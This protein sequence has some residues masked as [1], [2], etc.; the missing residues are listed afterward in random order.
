MR[1]DTFS[2]LGN[3]TP[4]WI[5]GLNN[6]FSFKGFT[7][8][9]LI[10]FVQGNQIT[11]DTRYQMM[12]NGTGKFTEQYRE[13]SAPLPGVVA[14]TT[15]T[16]TKYEKNTQLVDGQTAWAMRAW[17]DIG[18]EV[19]LNGS[20]V[21]LREVILGYT[22]K[23]SF[24]KKTPFKSIGV[25]LVGRNLWYIEEHM[26]GMGISPEVNLNTQAAASGVEV[27]SMPTTRSYGIN[28]NFT[29]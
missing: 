26:K 3:T 17:G 8:N 14:V 10:D 19:V 16:G 6:T 18:E 9:V 28:F 21:K 22:V 15:P 7:L 23:P 11:S 5:G 25:S 13:H 24:I 12:A 29:F 20:Y 2:V 27:L 4:K 1:T